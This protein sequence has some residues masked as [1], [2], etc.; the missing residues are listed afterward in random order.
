MWKRRELALG[1]RFWTASC[2]R[3][4]RLRPCDR[5]N[6]LFSSKPLY[7][8]YMLLQSSMPTQWLQQFNSN[9][10]SCRI[11]I[12]HI[13]KVVRSAKSCGRINFDAGLVS[14]VGTF[15]R[16][17]NPSREAAIRTSA[18]QPRRKK[19]LRKAGPIQTSTNYE[20]CRE[21]DLHAAAL[22]KQSRL[23]SRLN[24]SREPCNLRL[25]LEICFCESC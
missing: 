6:T 25:H 1:R 19:N 21:E 8:T 3:I 7:I 15:L 5:I 14:K 12:S 16:T 20:F 24:A 10:E 4:S 2:C 23:P 17:R 18:Y 11:S 9:P 22:R 13:L